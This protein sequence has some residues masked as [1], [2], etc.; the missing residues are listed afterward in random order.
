MFWICEREEA[1]A[2]TSH[3]VEMRAFCVLHGIV[4]A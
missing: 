1:A 4:V 2:W 3:G